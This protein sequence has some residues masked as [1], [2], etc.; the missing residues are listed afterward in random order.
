MSWEC[1][2]CHYRLLRAKLKG[3]IEFSV[4]VFCPACGREMHRPDVLS[5]IDGSDSGLTLA[6]FVE[7]ESV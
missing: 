3:T 2:S 1:G 6:D 7:G 4:L 5:E